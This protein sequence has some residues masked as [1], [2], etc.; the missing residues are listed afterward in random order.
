MKKIVALALCLV[1][2]LGLMTGC[3]KS[4]DAKTL[5][6]KMGEAVKTVTAQ[7][8]DAELELEMKM[9]SM[10]VTMS[11]GID[12][13][14]S[15]KAKADMSAMYVDMNMAME[16][17]GQS[18]EM[19]MQMYAAMEDGAMVYY[20]YESTEDMWVRTVQADYAEMLNSLTGMQL[21]F[22]DVSEE[23]LSMAK[24][25]QTVNGTKCYVLTEQIDG[26][27]VQEQM[28]DYMTQMLPQLAGTEELDEE[29]M[30]QLE[31]MMESLDW[32]KLSGS[33]VY[34]VDAETFLP[35]EMSVEILGLG[36]VFN[37]M[38][39]TLMGELM[40]ELDEETPAFAIEIPTLKIVTR[41][42]TY[43]DAVEI[44]AVPQEAIDNAIDADALA[45]DEYVDDEYVDDELI[46][47][48]PQADGSYLMTM[49]T[50][51][52]RVTVPEGY[53]A[54]VAEA[55]VLVF[56]T[57]DMM[58]TVNYMLMPDM[59]AADMEASVLDEVA[60]TQEENYYKSHTEVAELSGFQTMSL[61]Y[62]DGNSLWYAWKELD[63][64]L[65]MMYAGIAGETFDLAGLIATVEITAE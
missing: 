42:M 36:E 47:N 34:Y 2:V 54:Y 41:N 16:A 61:I 63:G 57:E 14:M 39:Q 6:Q 33:S 15:M 9:S 19:Q 22:T 24:E 32:T 28:G 4:M 7:A 55:E 59:T 65:L 49:G 62:N 23:N 31:T 53:E 60:W 38:I 25:Q 21:Q 13:D 48:E 11:M 17:L 44:P 18:E 30:A 29:T 26:A 58:N 43:N 35:L 56:V 64:G 12:M 37:G 8:M 40:M 46:T 27:A 51:T 3:Q 1:M 5:Y 52:I 45:D 20:A 50:D 10:G